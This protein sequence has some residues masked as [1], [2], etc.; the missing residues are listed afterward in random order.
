[1]KFDPVEIR[2]LVHVHSKRTGS[3]LHDEDLEQDIALEALEAQWSVG[4]DGKVTIEKKSASIAQI[5]INQTPPQPELPAGL[6][7]TP[8][9]CGP[10]RE[11]ICNPFVIAYGTSG[12]AEANELNKKNAEKLAA[13]RACEALSI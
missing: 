3:P 1:M 11:A 5:A 10:V 2:S 4:A 13:E 9:R 8:Q 7:K 6:R 12:S